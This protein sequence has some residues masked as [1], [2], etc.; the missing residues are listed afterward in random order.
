MKSE[1]MNDAIKAMTGIDVNASIENNVCATC[2]KP[3][4]KFRDPLS[5]KEFEIS[6]MCQTCQD[7]IWGG[8]DEFSF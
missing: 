1:E 7:S 5:E 8:E 3:V 2:G 6:G 4:T